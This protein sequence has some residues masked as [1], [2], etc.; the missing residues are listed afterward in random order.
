MWKSCL[1]LLPLGVICGIFL[2]YFTMESSS[3][4]VFLKKSNVVSQ[5]T[6]WNWLLISISSFLSFL[7]LQFIIFFLVFYDLEDQ[8]V[9][10][11]EIVY[12]KRNMLLQKICHQYN[13]TNTR[14]SGNFLASNLYFHPQYR[15]NLSQI[16]LKMSHRKVNWNYLNYRWDPFIVYLE[17]RNFQI[18]GLYS[19]TILGF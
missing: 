1:L 2:I 6:W 18:L 12:E 9:N 19:H 15:V 3:N 13:M 16:E 11:R 8:N 5:S 17:I 4:L 10:E 14:I 7:K